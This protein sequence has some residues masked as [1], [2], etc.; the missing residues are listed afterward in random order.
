MHMAKS[1]GKGKGSRGRKRKK[2]PAPP[3]AL[4]ESGTNP[5]SQVDDGLSPN[6]LRQSD[7]LIYESMMRGGGEAFGAPYRLGLGSL[8]DKIVK[9]FKQRSFF[10]FETFEQAP[11]RQHKNKFTRYGASRHF[12]EYDLQAAGKAKRKKERR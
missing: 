10:G 4:E 8:T 6:H 11:D 12:G 2:M 9:F 5:L 3:Q 1:Q 7:D